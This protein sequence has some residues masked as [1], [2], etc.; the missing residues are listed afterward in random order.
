M[1]PTLHFYVWEKKKSRWSPWAIGLYWYQTA[2]SITYTPIYQLSTR[3]VTSSQDSQKFD[4][5]EDD[6][7]DDFNNYLGR[8][9][10]VT[11]MQM[12][13]MVS[14]IHIWLL[15]FIKPFQLGSTRVSRG[16]LVLLQ[17]WIPSTTPGIILG[18]THIWCKSMLKVNTQQLSKPIPI[19]GQRW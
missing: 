16:P 12:K 5:G 17:S 14:I 7:E 13:T 4:Y 18:K 11:L 9:T 19:L 6:N 10:L 2:I 3:N 15:S 8:R 1:S